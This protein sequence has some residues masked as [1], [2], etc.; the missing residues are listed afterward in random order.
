VFEARTDGEFC[1]PSIEDVIKVL[2]GE[3]LIQ[4]SPQETLRCWHIEL[5]SL[6]PIT[7]EFL[8]ALPPRDSGA[9]K[10]FKEVEPELIRNHLLARFYQKRPPTPGERYGIVSHSQICKLPPKLRRWVD[11]EWYAEGSCQGG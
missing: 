8:F 2:Q 3:G 6:A 1:F 4:G 7:E 9:L 5:I 10:V 11:P